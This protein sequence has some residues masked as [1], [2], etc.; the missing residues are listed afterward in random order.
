M[1]FDR[2]FERAVYAYLVIAV[3]FW[4]VTLTWYVITDIRYR[5]RR[6]RKDTR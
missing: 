5:R 3:V 6:A 4:P 2:D 1:I